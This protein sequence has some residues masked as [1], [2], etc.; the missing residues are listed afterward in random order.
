[1]SDSISLED[2]LGGRDPAVYEVATRAAGPVGE[3]PLTGPFLAHAPSGDL[4]GLIQDVGM[5]WK[6]SEAPADAFLLLSH[7]GGIRGADGKPVALGYHVGHYEL[8]LLMEAAAREFQVLGCKPFAACCTDPCDGRTQ[9]TPGMMDSLAY[10]NEAAS[11]FRRLI[12]SLPGRKGVL[13][14]ATCDKSLPAVMMALASMH[15]LPVA[16]VP[17]GVTL[18]PER[19]EDLG[20]IQSIGARFA[21]SE[22]TLDYAR[23]MTC[24]ACASAGGGC[25]FLG[26]AATAQVVAEA[27][28]L[29][30]PH[31]ALAPSGQEIWLDIARRSARALRRLA[32]DGVT[33]GRIVT[34]ASLRNAMAVFAA[35]GGST[36]LLLHIPAIA[37]AAGLDRPT[38]DDWN[39][40][41][42][43]TPRLVD[44][45][46]NGPVGHPTVRAYL[47]GGVPEVMLHLRQMGLLD[48]EVLTVAGQSLGRTLD[49]WQRSDRRRRLREI[50]HQKDGID[51]DD[52]IMP[53]DRARARGLTGTITLPQ[54]NLA[55]AGAVIKSTAIDPSLVDADGVYRKTGPA[56]V[57]IGERAGIQ[58][59]RAGVVQPGDVMAVICAGPLGSGMEETLEVTGALKNL[60]WGKHV[61]VLTD[62]R[63]S[64][65]STGACIGHIGP[66][67]LAGGPIGKLR[68]GDLI[69]IVIDCL[70][71]E[72][73]LDL[74][75]QADTAPEQRC[76]ELGRRILAQRPPRPDLVP[77][78]DLPDD[79]RLWAALQEISG[80]TWAGCVFDAKEILRTLEAGRR[81]KME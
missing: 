31:A 56:R 73:S 40:V 72:G 62:G 27:L 20:T 52:V 54:G 49:W 17:G 26:T 45:L 15:E 74:I 7:Q 64:G 33:A 47:A 9:G 29:T 53:P 55:P 3:L 18:P 5:G 39:T 12:R 63:F 48:M 37:Y 79:T 58:A 22:V 11:I 76:P 24:R 50:L 35:F 21:R 8:G 75:G 69:Q 65:V 2:I 80:G 13:G 57:F 10:R 28:G 25:Q 44:V 68:D 34:K 61:A 59:I 81:N 51:P 42:R 46:P 6:P 78:S 30:L 1:M 43:K 16:I 23:Q 67:A 38:I 70:H 41:N 32:Q 66:E 71:L 14:V 60:S 36:N 19:G 77:Y 4:F